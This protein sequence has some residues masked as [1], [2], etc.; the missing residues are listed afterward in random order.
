MSI[1][2][3]IA[4]LALANNN[5][6][7]AATTIINGGVADRLQTANDVLSANSSA[8]AAALSASSFTAN[9]AQMA[10]S[11]INTQALLVSH[12]ATATY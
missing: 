3:Q 6:T 12:F 2:S 11:I 5:L 9:F 4:G 8:T 7:A 10:T 1:E